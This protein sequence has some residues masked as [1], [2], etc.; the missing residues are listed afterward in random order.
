MVGMEPAALAL[1]GMGIGGLAECELR[2]EFA[3]SPSGIP[4]YPR[5][6]DYLEHKLLRWSAF[7]EAN[8]VPINVGEYGLMPDCHAPGQ[9]GMTWLT[10]LLELMA[11]TDLNFTLYDYHSGNH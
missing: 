10:D 9:G 7:G 6:R 3:D 11:P 4:V 8:N 1:K 5:N 2:I